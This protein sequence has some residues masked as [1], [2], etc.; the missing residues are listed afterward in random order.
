MRQL[1]TTSVVSQDLSRSLNSLERL[2]FIVLAWSG[3]SEVSVSS[4]WYFEV[5]ENGHV[6]A[7]YFISSIELFQLPNMPN[8][9]QHA[10]KFHTGILQN[11]RKFIKMSI[12]QN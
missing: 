8:A 4:S 3:R 5:S 10:L 2:L 7:V 1:V 12:V 6:S 9:I 11:V